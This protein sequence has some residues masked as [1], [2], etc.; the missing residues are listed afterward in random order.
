MCMNPWT[1]GVLPIKLVE[2]I[3]L[4]LNVTCTNLHNQGTREHIRAALRAGATREEIL[5]ILKC[6]SLLAIHSCSLGAPIL[7]EE[8]RDRNKA[9][10]E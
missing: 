4:G 3:S 1:N 6:A 8:A 10:S 2:L 5:C 9:G 7:L